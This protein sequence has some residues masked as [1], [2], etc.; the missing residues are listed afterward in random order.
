MKIKLSSPLTLCV[1]VCA[2]F[3]LFCTALAQDTGFGGYNRRGAAFDQPVDTSLTA[4][5]GQD[6]VVMLEGKTYLN[7]YA[8]YGPPRQRNRGGRRRGQA[9][10]TAAPTG[11]EPTVVW[12]KD[13]GPGTVTFQ[14]AKA[15]STT[16]T[17]SAL[18]NYVL[19]LTA[20]NG[21]TT[22][23]S[24]LTVK[25]EAPPPKDRLD[26]VYTKKYKIDNPLWNSRAKALIVGWIP[27]CIDMINTP[28]LRQGGGGIDNFIDAAKA[29]R[30]EPY[31]YHRGYVF[32]NA[33]VHQ[34]VESMC[35]ALMV[36][37]QGD[38]DSSSQQSTITRSRTVPTCVFTMRRRNCATAGLPI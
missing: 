22:D 5:A 1:L 12:S 32:S 26:V 21:E 19:K 27:H 24:T 11:P 20:D 14:D 33:W 7:G 36:D 4:I 17:F 10:Q 30:C 37:P 25:V 23:S 6:R 31:Q 3:V 13:S 34:T 35:I 15:K 8:G 9:E 28:D 29:L 2:V 18:G 16:A 38:A